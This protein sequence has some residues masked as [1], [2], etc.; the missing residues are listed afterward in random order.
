LTRTTPVHHRLVYFYSIE[1]LNQSKMLTSANLK[2]PYPSPSYSIAKFITLPIER[3][4]HTHTHTHNLHS[5]KGR[6]QTEILKKR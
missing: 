2:D 3:L 4:T 1:I 5:I 6:V